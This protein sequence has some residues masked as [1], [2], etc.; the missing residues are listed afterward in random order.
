MDPNVV[1]YCVTDCKF[2]IKNV[3]GKKLGF[4]YL[5]LYFIKFISCK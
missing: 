3:E 1:L 2:V 4:N 5:Y